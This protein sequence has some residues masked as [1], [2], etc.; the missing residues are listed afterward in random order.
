VCR[1]IREFHVVGNNDQID[2]AV[3]S[4]LTRGDRPKDEGKLDSICQW[5]QS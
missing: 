5:R 3:G 4:L 1:K 2:V